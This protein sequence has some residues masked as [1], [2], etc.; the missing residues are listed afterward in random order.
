MFLVHIFTILIRNTESK[1]ADDDDN[2][3]YDDDS[4]YFIQILV[5]EINS[6]VSFYSNI[7]DNLQEGINL[8]DFIIPTL[9]YKKHLTLNTRN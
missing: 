8:Q 5:D 4:V 6:Y 3:D 7:W 1:K 9:N 2:N